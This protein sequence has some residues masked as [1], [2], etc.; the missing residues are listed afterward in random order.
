M[1]SEEWVWRC[2]VFMDSIFILKRM[3]EAAWIPNKLLYLLDVKP[4]RISRQHHITQ[5]KPIT[6]AANVELSNPNAA[7]GIATIL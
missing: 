3:E 4:H 6:I 5:L 2:I 1:S 7:I